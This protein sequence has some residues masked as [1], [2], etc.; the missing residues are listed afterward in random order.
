MKFLVALI[1]IA[2]GLVALALIVNGLIGK[3]ARRPEDSALR[4]AIDANLVRGNLPKDPLTQIG[5]GVALLLLA[6]GL[7]WILLFGDEMR[8]WG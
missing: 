8:G 6:A 4:K 1:P 3:Y 2:L 7:A 5:A